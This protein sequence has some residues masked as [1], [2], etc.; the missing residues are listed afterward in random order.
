MLNSG[1]G[2]LPVSKV[3]EKIE[4]ELISPAQT[5]LGGTLSETGIRQRLAAILAA[6]VAGYSRLMAGDE[7]ATVTALDAA[8][9]V[10]KSR[11]ESHQGRVID[12]AGDSVLA[13]FET[14]TGAVSAALAVQEELKIQ[15][16][17]APENRRMRF[18]IGVHLGDVIEKPDGTIYGDGVNIAA[19]LE[20]LAEPG[21]ITVSESIRTAVQSK[22]RA[23]FEDQG[24][25]AVKNIAERVRVFRIVLEARAGV[26]A[27]AAGAAALALP[28]KPSIAV[29]PF[30]NMSGDPEQ[31]YFSDGVTEDIITELSHFRE[32]FVIA[33]NSSFVF[34]GQS[35]D[36]TD[37]AKKL[38]VQYILEGSVRKVGKRVRITA[39]LVDS[40]AA[41]HVWADRY[42]RDLEDIFAVQDEVVRTI[43]GTLAG[44]LEQAVRER[45]K[46]KST[47]NL[48]AYEY[49]L[50]A[51]EY[52]YIW[53][54]K[55]NRTAR[56]MFEKAIAIDP[57]YA[58]AYAGLAKTHY[59]DWVSGW[60]RDSGASLGC[61]FE[62][63]ER[64]VTLD[65][66]DSRTHTALGSA[67]LFRREHDRAR[68][69]FE[70]ALGLNAS[71]TR[72]LV[73]M[74][75]YEVNV[76]NPEQAVQRIIQAC[77]LNP[78]GNF[79]W[80]LGQA[81]FA[82]RRYEE[83]ID[84]LKKIRNPV[85]FVRSWLVASLGQAG[86]E[87]E[88]QYAARE[89]VT[90]AEAELADIGVPYPQSW[91]EFIAARCPF[92]QHAEL[93]HLLHGL[94]KAGLSG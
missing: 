49:L 24:E 11:I 59:M 22:V 14:A 43:V 45:A 67:Y 58:A 28:D 46:R 50:Q 70:R 73:N 84:A 1:W 32:L 81:H 10:F 33:R 2:W 60:C 48:K 74:A 89:L 63:A 72:A 7:R 78:F 37:V 86:R 85:A 64:S 62:N 12:M 40:I 51:R 91:L 15:A 68:H 66:A 79:N 83:A 75:R 19:R 57:A 88:A 9:S 5:S 76:G 39:Q 77:R 61:F 92:K 21:G 20:A 80:Y 4:S 71:D 18:R 17:E 82:G 41:N 94:R 30:T 56:E 25:Q 35:V 52:Y 87:D 29:L 31:Q 42:D 54:P 44:R 26:A 47:S 90:V 13:V 34:K 23:A 6:D 38:G 55:D 93:E 16:S 27:P 8:R 65:D 53:T 36:I 69:H 3:G